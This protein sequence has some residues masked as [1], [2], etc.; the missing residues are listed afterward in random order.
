MRSWA[1]A[2]C[3][4]VRRASSRLMT[5]PSGAATSF[6]FAVVAVPFGG[7]VVGMARRDFGVVASCPS[8]SCSCSAAIPGAAMRDHEGAGEPGERCG[9]D[10]RP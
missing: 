10:P 5:G 9:S 3:V 6:R 4:E 1:A 8:P 2:R 7:A